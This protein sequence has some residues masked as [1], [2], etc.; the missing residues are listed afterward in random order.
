MTEW[1]SSPEIAGNDPNWVS[2]LRS[3][4]SEKQ[5]SVELKDIVSK[6]GN[7]QRLSLSDGHILYHHS[8]LYEVGQLANLVKIARYGKHV[9]FNSNVHINQTNI[10]VLACKF[11]AFRRSKKQTD[12]YELSI[13]NYLEEMAKFS[14]SIDEV[15]SVGGLHPDWEVNFY[16]DLISAAK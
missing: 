16:V 10:C 12:A 5:W 3:L 8:S 7:G 11:C 1:I 4:L 15:H 9:F 2:N 13:E 14:K 6:L